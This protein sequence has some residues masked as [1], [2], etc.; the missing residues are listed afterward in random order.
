MEP[1]STVHGSRAL[2]LRSETLFNVNPEKSEATV[3]TDF[4]IMYH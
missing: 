4:C 3:R 1:S 2:I